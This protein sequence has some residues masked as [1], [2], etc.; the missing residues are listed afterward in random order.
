MAW[1]KRLNIWRKARKCGSI[2]N[3]EINGCRKYQPRKAENGIS[4]V[5]WLKR[6]QPASGK[7]VMAK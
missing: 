6:K 1:R 2:N 7:K 4:N 5:S 3:E